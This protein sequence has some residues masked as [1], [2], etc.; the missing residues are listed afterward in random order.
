LV[1][2]LRPR[3]LGGPRYGPDAGPVVTGQNRAVRCPRLIGREPEFAQVD[4][5]VAA[6]RAGGGSSIVLAGDAGI[7]KTRLAEYAVG[8]GR[9]LGVR[10][11]VC[12]PVPSAVPVPLRAVADALP[13]A[14]R[15]MSPPTGD[16]IRPYLPVSRRART[17]L[18]GEGVAS[19][20]LF[21]HR[22]LLRPD[23]G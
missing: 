2:V 6:A 1:R 18:A 23:V 11:L 9:P 17:A 13:G 10:V 15:A 14:V 16:E 21:S 8:E 12:R 3:R 22:L 20:V 7:G 5:V 4:G 19:R